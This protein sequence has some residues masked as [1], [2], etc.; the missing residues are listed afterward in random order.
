MY[1]DANGDAEGN[2]SVIALQKDDKVNNSLHMSMQPVALFAYG[3]RNATGTGTTLPEF[4]YLNPNRP[5]M[6]LKG[7]PP[8]AEPICGFYNEKCRPKAKDWRYITG[9]L[10][11]ILFM[12]IFTIILFK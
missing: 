8:L 9:A 3:A 11:V 4:R 7:R 1:I 2:F 5:I 12:A 6:W 10:V